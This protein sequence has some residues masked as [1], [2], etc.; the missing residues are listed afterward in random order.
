VARQQAKHMCGTAP[1]S[2][3]TR[4]STSRRRRRAPAVCEPL[5]SYPQRSP[6]GY[7]RGPETHSRCVFRAGRA[8]DVPAGTRSGNRYCKPLYV[9]FVTTTSSDV[10]ELVQVIVAFDD[11]EAQHQANAWSWLKSTADIFRRS[12]PKT[13]PKHLVPYLLLR[14]STDGS[15]FLMH[16][17]KAGLWLP[18]SGHVERA[19]DPTVCGTYW[20]A[21]G[22]TV[23]TMTSVC[24]A[25]HAGGHP[26]KWQTAT[27]I[28]WSRIFYGFLPK[29]TPCSALPEI[30]FTRSRPGRAQASQRQQG[31][32]S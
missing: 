17:R 18:T 30:K 31:G 5:I 27:R 13:P 22:T 14:D 10:T 23:S 16:H 19:E 24:S 7:V 8:T 26:R 20:P 29:P 28:S 1:R 25:R 15:A 12:A 2:N 21:R 11:V 32:G 3:L 4:I 9:G 6:N